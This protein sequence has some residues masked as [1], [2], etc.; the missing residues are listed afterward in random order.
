MARGEWQRTTELIEQM[1]RTLEQIHPATI[2]QLFYQLLPT[3]LIANSRH[4]YQR[5]SLALVMAKARNDGRVPFDYIVDRSRPEYTPNVFTD[6][7]NY[8]RVVKRG[9]RKDYWSTQ[10]EYVE[11]WAEKDAIVGSI[12]DLTEEL[13]ITV[14]VGRGFLST[15]KA[16]EI[17][18]HFESFDKPI[19]VF[20]LGDHDPSGR[21]IE[22]DLY[23]RILNYGTYDG[24]DFDLRRLAIHKADITKFRL[25]PLR[26]KDGDSRSTSFRKKYGTECVEL[27]ALPP[28]ELRKRIRDA[29]EDLTD[30]ELWSKSV[31]VE[32]A[33]LASIRDFADKWSAI[34]HGGPGGRK[35][36][37][38]A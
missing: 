27:D 5:V 2:R 37:S 29:V 4:G 36:A 33:E 3:G 1:L 11:L 21:A 24:F 10:P 13:G 16:H 14:R 22:S 17:A 25:P 28:T 26:I 7:A 8:A 31:A 38:H 9:Y 30:L 12:Q 20:Y 32:K 6:A 19:T 15:T 23:K 18:E 34:L 35:D